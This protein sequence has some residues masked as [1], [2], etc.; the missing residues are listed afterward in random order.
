MFTPKKS[1]VLQA[2]DVQE[3]QPTY[4]WFDYETSGPHPGWDRPTQVAMIRTTMDFQMVGQEESFKIQLPEDVL[5][6]PR[7]MA[8][9]QMTPQ[10]LQQEGISEAEAARRL[11]AHF[12]EPHTCLVGYNSHQFDDEVTRH[13]FYRNFKPTYEHE[14]KNGNSRWDLFG[15][16]R[17]FYALAPQTLSWVFDEAGTPKF[18]L[19]G[20]ALANGFRTGQAHEALSDVRA[21]MALA[22][23]LQSRQPDLFSSLFELRHKKAI[24]Q[25]VA[26]SLKEGF[27][28]L[29]ASSFN[30]AS[31]GGVSM[32]LPLGMHPTRPNLLMA[33][34]LHDDPQMTLTC[35]EESLFERLTTPL[36]EGQSK[37]AIRLIPIN[38]L[39]TL[40]HGRWIKDINIQR[41][42]WDLVGIQQ[43]ARQWMAQRAWQ[44]TFSGVM[45]RVAQWQ[46]GQPQDRL[47]S[48]LSLYQGFFSKSD[49]YKTRLASQDI[50]FT[51]TH[52]FEDDRLNCLWFRYRAR[53]FPHTLGSTEQEKW[54]CHT[55]TWL[56]HPPKPGL[57]L[58]QYHQAIDALE[59]APDGLKSALRAWA[60]ELA[61]KVGL[62]KDELPN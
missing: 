17:M 57:N 7:A 23:T 5:P 12:T 11:Y 33:V 58:A 38:R 42:G 37:L 51:Q 31:S 1:V 43:H 55:R 41:L 60:A 62:K 2:Q 8:L 45:K 56:N 46:D 40:L 52:D 50:A 22:Q 4:L 19:E 53:H 3:P 21:L 9:T 54:R 28:L 24:E 27:P 47:D 39:P 48:E 15:V 34:D 36:E 10:Q 16:V 18:G 20:L 14:W 25:L 29:Y 59:D 32:I 6:H 13:V 44:A 49:E 26:Q 30:P 61:Q 35:T